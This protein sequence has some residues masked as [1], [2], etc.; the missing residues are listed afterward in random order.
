M[1]STVIIG[2]ML[3]LAVWAI[4]NISLAVKKRNSPSAINKYFWQM[5]GLWNIINL[6]IAVGAIFYTITNKIMLN[7]DLSAQQTQI[8]IVAINILLDIFYIVIGLWLENRGK[9][10]SNIRQQGYGSAIQ[11]QGAFL[12]FFDTALTAALIIAI[13]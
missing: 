6:T 5:N 11:L 7:T 8:K 9:S 1:F 10:F 4:A 3:V 2:A 13:I 12:F